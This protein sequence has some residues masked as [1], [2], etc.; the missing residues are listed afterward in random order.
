MKKKHLSISQMWKRGLSIVIAS[1]MTIT[2]VPAF[3]FS[4]S[5]TG[6]DAPTLRKAGTVPAS[7]ETMTIG[8]PF[9]QGTAGCERFR[10]PALLTLEN[11]DLFAT[12]D[13]R[14]GVVDG[15][16]APDGGGLDSIASVSSDGGKTWN[17]SFPFYFPDC[18]GNDGRNATTIIDPSVV[19]GPDGTIYCFADV[20]PSGIT[21]MYGAIKTG[22]G[23]VLVDGKPY[24]AL[25]DVYA[26]AD[27]EPTDSD[28]TTYPY[29]VDDFDENGYAQILRRED[30]TPT[31][32]GVDEWYNLYHVQDGEYVM[33]DLTQKQ[34]NTDTDIQQNAYYKDSSFHVYNIGYIWVITSKDHG[35]TWEHPRNINYQVKRHSGENAI[36]VSPGK[37]LT[38]ED[39]TIIMG[40]Y[41]A[42]DGEENA[43]F[44]Y[45]HDNGETW[46]RTEDVPGAAVG[47][48]RSSEHEI[49]ELE[50]G[51]L[52]MFFR[53]GD[54]LAAV[55]PLAYADATRQPDGSYEFGE[56]QYSTANLQTGC[57][58]TAI[59]YSKKIDGKQV[60]MVAGPSGQRV[61]GVILTFLVNDDAEHSMELINTFYVP[62][63]QGSYPS[64]VY[65]CLTELKD[66][67]IGLIWEPNHYSIRYSHFSIHD[68]IPNKEI[69]GSPAVKNIEV[70]QGDIY[71]E[72]YAGE[73]TVTA[74]PDAQIA[75]LSADKKTSFLMCDHSGTVSEVPINSFLTEANPSLVLSD[76]EF[77]FTGSDN[78]WQI[79]NEATGLYLTNETNAD[80]FFSSAAADMTAAP[81]DGQNTFRIC[82][83]SGQRYVVFYS[84]GMNFN[85]NT[86][87][88]QGDSSYELVLLEKQEE[89]SDDASVIPGYNQ[90]S[91]ISSGK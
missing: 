65:S 9:A 84:A 74:E 25:T 53:R 46:G 61:N 51:T 52:R 78:T 70:A 17:Y 41:N 55:G 10:I 44:I 2:M 72:S 59:S 81:T 54:Y 33:G 4:A 77:T 6:T 43:S 50:D 90:V 24:L 48:T 38:T 63:G 36:L 23:Y 40:F 88:T 26:N 45:S 75:A 29:Y 31:G 79:K 76:A 15:T 69:E 21:T 67:S 91:V 49:V 66:G 20:N 71:T 62:E 5:A 18:E 68:V 14:Y 34:T 28:F 19:E 80:E 85:S 32:Y 39:G 16:D 11:G 42:N 73:G 56:V 13:A 58:L 89:A 12:A 3:T 64:Y 30:S 87:Y 60:I 22:T 47:G 57:N 86:N 27:T 7:A 35:R 1:A 83:A 82:K 8:E 37:G